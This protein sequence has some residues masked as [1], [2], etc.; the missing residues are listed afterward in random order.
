MSI[1]R[2]M[3]PV[4]AELDLNE[5]GKTVN[6]A[7]PLSLL[8]AIWDLNIN[9]F[10]DIGEKFLLFVSIVHNGQKVALQEFRKTTLY[11]LSNF[12]ISKE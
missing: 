3:P 8:T 6:Q 4:L 11:Y 9:E 7:K 1:S 5:S 12:Y 2:K 10:C